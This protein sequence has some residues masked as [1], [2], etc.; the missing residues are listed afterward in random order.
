MIKATT[1]ILVSLYFCGLSFSAG[2]AHP[3]KSASAPAKVGDEA[4]K[5]RMQLML[6]DVVQLLPF[7]FDE[8]KFTDQKNE[9][10]IE[11]ALKGLATHSAE[12]KQHTSHMDRA[13]GLKI[14]PSFPFIADSFEREIA[15]AQQSFND[16]NTRS[17]SQIILRSALAKCTMCHSQS[18]VGPTLKLKT[19]NSTL[20]NLP[21][22]D[23]LMAL[24]VTRQF[25][26]ALI[27]FQ[28]YAK[29][30][31]GVKPKTVPFDK[32]VRALLAVAVRVKRDPLAAGRV[33]SAAIDSGAGSTML[34]TDLASWKTAVATWQQEKPPDLNSDQMLFSEAKKLTNRSQDS[35]R[36]RESYVSDAVSYLRASGYLHDLL[37]NYP[38]SSL[39]AE[40]YILL[41]S[42]YESLPGFAIWDL[43]DEYLGACIEE[44]P[45]SNNGE[46]CFSLYNDSIVA[47]YT[48]SSGTHLPTAV[49]DHLSHMKSI[50]QKNTPT[51]SPK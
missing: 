4:W 25:E 10:T 23:R 47:G 18:A 30:A 14:D 16:P 28:Q 36:T 15:Q 31:K 51:E 1:L 5:A 49:K 42:I 26:E 7:A 50:S 24:T 32:N 2:A 12:L 11:T 29:E 46:R 37:S 43:G 21:L 9:S 13:K 41:A 40:S 22:S 6:S 8:V 19:F 38:E 34:Q 48:G 44:N 3:V 17:E 27:A 39:R 35:Q 33:I 45:H 20:K